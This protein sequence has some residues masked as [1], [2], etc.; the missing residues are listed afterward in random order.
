ML[1]THFEGMSAK[2]DLEDAQREV[3]IAQR[4]S[5]GQGNGKTHPN[6]CA[7]LDVFFS[8]PAHEKL[9]LVFQLV[10]GVD[11]L[12]LLNGAGGR[13]PEQRARR[14]FRHLLSGIKYIHANGLTHRDIKPENC[15]IEQKS[16]RLKIID[17]GLSKTLNS[18][19]C[20]VPLLS[21]RWLLPP[22]ASCPQRAR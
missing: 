19:A 14:Y 13:I 3:A 1:Y 18:G 5:G 15:M 6:I 2:H 9:I 17:F 12:D 22:N 20:L 7:L 4:L 11:L 16:D 21:A 8:S 10:E